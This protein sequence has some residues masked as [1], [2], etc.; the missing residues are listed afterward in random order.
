MTYLTKTATDDKLGQWASWLKNS[1][2]PW[3]LR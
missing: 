1:W 3:P 2:V